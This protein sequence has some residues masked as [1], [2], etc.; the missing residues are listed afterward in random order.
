MSPSWGRVQLYLAPDR[1]VLRAGGAP[2]AAD[3]G[4]PGWAGVLAALPGLLASHKPAG[5]VTILLSSHFAPLWLLPGAPTRL[6][7]E[8]S[9]GWVESQVAERFGELAANWRLAFRPAP[10]GVPILAA[11][12]D[13]GHW[14]EL[15]R[16]LA[17]AGLAAATVTSWVAPTLARHAGH[18]AARLLLAEAGRLTLVSL[19]RGEPVALESARGGP[20]ALAGLLARAELVD[21]LGD[22]PLRLVG[23]GVAGDWNGARVLANAPEAALPSGC[24]ALDFLPTRQQQPLA[25]WLLLAAG[26]GLA[27]LAGNHHMTLAEQLA[28]LP[29]AAPASVSAR[30]RQQPTTTDAPA[31]R[32]WGDLL[33]RLESQR[34]ARIAL[35]SL[36]GDAARGEA[37]ITAEARSEADMLDWLKALRGDAGFS[38]ASLVQHTVRHEDAQQP[39]RFEIRLDWGAR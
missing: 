22:A 35:L 21:G 5:R 4:D 38:N 13:A 18:G 20:E 9:R 32:P 17:Q 30:P 26:L 27:A 1:V 14:A 16:A 7:F 34:P 3:I 23:T 6:N 28:A 29:A 2:H 36:R 24:G 39:L 31:A 10:A 19:A 15:L 33:N 37:R 11:G 8:E 25:A 12:I